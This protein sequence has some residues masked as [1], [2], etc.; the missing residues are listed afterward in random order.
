MQGESDITASPSARAGSPG[1]PHELAASSEVRPAGVSP[2][3]S[4][5]LSPSRPPR[6]CAPCRASYAKSAPLDLQRAWSP[7][8]EWIQS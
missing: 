1:A 2:M 8:R 5:T 4:P 3:L 7:R 6:S